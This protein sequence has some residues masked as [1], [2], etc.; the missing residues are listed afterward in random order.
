MRRK[1]HEDTRRDFMKRPFVPLCIF[2]LIGILMSHYR[3]RFIPIHY[4]VWAILASMIV[5]FLYEKAFLLFLAISIVLLG[6]YI[7]G[8]SMVGDILGGALLNEGTISAGILKE[9]SYKR[10]YIEYEVELLGLD[11]DAQKK[12]IKINKNAQ[13]KIYISST[14]ES[15]FTVNDVIEIKHSKV[16]RLLKSKYDENDNSYEI[17]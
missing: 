2:L 11:F 14:G 6:S 1:I 5:L 16:T 17:F 10:G 13:L 3:E 9:A 7:Y 4:L 8:Q 15:D 12:N